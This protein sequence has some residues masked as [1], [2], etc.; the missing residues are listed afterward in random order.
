MENIEERLRV[1]ENKVKKLKIY[2][3]EVI[4]DREG[5]RGIFE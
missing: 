2:L 5:D 3:V 1:M 4:E